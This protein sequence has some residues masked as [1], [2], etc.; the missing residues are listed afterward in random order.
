MTKHAKSESYERTSDVG[1]GSQPSGGIGA[2]P[3]PSTEPVEC[4]HCGHVGEPTGKG[5]CSECRCWLP[6]NDAAVTHGLR[7]YED[8][9]VLPADLRDYLDA[10]REDVESD[11]GGVESLSAIQRGLVGNLCDLEAARL[12]LLDYALRQG[13]ETKRGRSAL[14]DHGQTVDRWRRTAKLLGLRRREKEVSLDDA[15]DAAN[16]RAS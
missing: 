5:Q 13:A 8:T 11:L 6:G 4:G 7:R 3:D 16:R 1:S 2:G 15:I 14:S 12:L 9:G 10:F